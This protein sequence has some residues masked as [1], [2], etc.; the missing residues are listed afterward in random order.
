MKAISSKNICLKLISFVL[1][2]L[3][4]L[5]TS[6]RTEV[7]NQKLELKEIDNA[8]ASQTITDRIHFIKTGKSDA[9][10]IE[11]NGHFGLVDA[12]YSSDS[13]RPESEMAYNSDYNGKTV[14]NYLA[15]VMGNKKLDF[16]IMSHA[17]S[18]HIGGVPDIVNFVNSNTV[19]FF[20]EYKYIDHEEK[21]LGWNNQY[22]YD[23][24][25]KKFKEKK[26]ILCE[27]SVGKNTNV[28][29]KIK[30]NN[31]EIKNIEFS[32]GTYAKTETIVDDRISFNFENYKISLYSLYHLYDVYDNP[33]TLITYI[34]KG[35][36]K[37]L[38]EGDVD[39]HKSTISGDE[40]IGV[41]C[42]VADVIGDISLMKAGHHGLRGSNSMY[43]LSK[44]KPEYV[45]IPT[46][47]SGTVNEEFRMAAGYLKDQG[48]KAYATGNS[49][50]AIVANIYKDS[51]TIDDYKSDYTRVG[52][53][54]SIEDKIPEGWCSMYSKLFG[55]VNLLYGYVDENGSLVKGWKKI[56]GEKGTFWYYF[57][58]DGVM[59]KSWV[60]TKGHTYYLN[61]TETDKL[62]IGA[63]ITGWKSVGG[64]WFYFCK[65]KNEFEGYY[66]GSM[67]KGWRNIEYSGKNY[68]F[69]FA[70]DGT[71][72]EGF[73][74]GQMLTGRQQV[75][76][77][78]KSSYYYFCKKKNEPDGYVKGAMINNMTYGGYTY[79]SSGASTDT[80]IPIAEVSYS[81][82][83]MTNKD[84][85]VTIKTNEE[86]KKISGWTLSNNQRE[87]TKTYKANRDE[88]VTVT[89]LAGNTKKVTVSIKNIDK[90]A[91]TLKVISSPEKLTNGNVTVTIT[92]NEK[93]QGVKGWTLS[94]DKKILTKEYSDNDTETV[95]VKDLVGNA[96]TKEIKVDNIDKEALR[97][98]ASYSTKEATNKDVIATI[99]SVNKEI[100]SISG[101][102]WTI[103]KN[104]KK[105]ATK[106][107]TE[108]GSET[109][110]V[111]DAA[112]NTKKITLKIENIDKIK[113]QLEKICNNTEKTNENVIVTLVSTE[114]IEIINAE[115]WTLSENKLKLIKEYKSNE[116]D[117]VKVR[118]L[119]GNIE[120]IKVEVTNIDKEGPELEVNYSTDKPINGNVTVTIKSTNEEIKGVEGW[121]LKKDKKT[122]VKTFVENGEEEVEVLD[123]AGNVANITVKVGNIIT[124]GPTITSEV[125]NVKSFWIERIKQNTTINNMI[126]N[127]LIQ[128]TNI[129]YYNNDD[130]EIST[131][132][133]A[134]TGMKIVLDD[135]AT[136]T[137]VVT[138]DVDGDGLAN[139]NDMLEI[140]RH[141]LL[142]NGSLTGIYFEAGDVT[143]DGEVD[144]YDMLEINRH[145][146]G[147]PW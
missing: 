4:I 78:G 133:K 114:E 142:E 128:A 11:S 39:V 57:N 129:K 90:T 54:I 74:E 113:P 12:S 22:Y 110:T 80:V 118:D 66:E 10:L 99:T 7:I 2:I 86:V 51:I 8:L 141:R 144:E 43:A 103:D 16:M 47:W 45:V 143:E 88:T 105:N 25:I 102:G 82:K 29:N 18:D 68:W 89:D 138:G 46:K 109:V 23:L 31:S 79:N 24:A 19:V 132:E 20:K 32:K 139:E 71:K 75:I 101:T 104:N 123:I 77:N 40:N 14:K 69:Y 58:E 64:K 95:N 115:G 13:T 33:N 56:T 84:V 146:L 26:A 111:K 96:T 63:M 127:I 134:K 70:E 37:I 135:Q 116:T 67:I 48:K 147:I 81:E 65:S 100:Q 9:T 107:F 17:H 27:T 125:Y 53:A 5:M 72:Y 124:E 112:G 30:E 73:K 3:I 83:S 130:K 87:L 122:L 85:K 137:L 28:F 120:T 55:T 93:I 119:S 121:N 76:Y 91:P 98:K 61:P 126:K 94:S 1:A 6:V 140:N 44:L 106:K 108:N 59:Q 52:S 35:T 42:Q 97:L 92:S 145:R 131:T 50:G 34:T 49:S 38:L 15:K 62:P 36:Q 21:D 117:I 60:K 136:Y 41:E